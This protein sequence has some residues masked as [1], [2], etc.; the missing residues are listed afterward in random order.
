MCQNKK[1]LHFFTNEY[2]YGNKSESFIVAELVYL[3][4]AFNKIIIYPS[5]KPEGIRE[6]PENVIVSDL[7]IHTE[8]ARLKKI[9]LL[10]EYLLTSLSI[11]LSEVKSKGLFKVLKNRNLLLDNI[12]TQLLKLKRFK[13]NNQFNTKDLFYDYWFENST[14]FLSIAKKKNYIT[15]FI[16]R[17]HGFDIY[18]ERWINIGVPFRDFKITYLNHLYIISEYGYN[19]VKQRTPSQFQN[20]LSISKLGVHQSPKNH[21]QKESNTIN[22]VSCSNILKFKQVHLIPELLVNLKGN[23]HWTHF[24]DG[25][26]KVKLESKLKTLPNNISVDLQGQKDNTEIYNFYT[27]NHVDLFLSL[28]TTEGIPVSMMEAQSY[29]IPIA[30]YN[31]GGIGEILKDTKTGIFLDQNSS[32]DDQAKQ[33]EEIL[34]FNFSEKVI[35]EFFRNNFDASFNY[36]KFIR[37]I[38]SII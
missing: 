31:V 27:N 12:S 19:Y 13:T 35:L 26:K 23:I 16:S 18:D 28:S 33:L 32:F 29:N 22:I 20:K 7:L 8:T 9:Q 4:R 1:T 15:K 38:E 10:F 2:P 37:E 11:L 17:G 3:S 36:P 25:P 5:Y 14:L 24:G 6:T 30:A 34:R 21:R